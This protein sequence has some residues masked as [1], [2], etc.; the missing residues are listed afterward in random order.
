MLN[1]TYF[2]VPRLESIDILP[3]S[4]DR[5]ICLEKLGYSLKLN[6]VKNKISNIHPDRWTFLRKKLNPLEYPY[7]SNVI[8]RPASRA[9]FKLLE[10]IK[11]MNLDVSGKT[12]HLAEAPGGFIQATRFCKKDNIE[13]YTFSII[14]DEERPVYKR[15]VVNKN[16]VI[17]SNKT[18]GGDICN[19]RNINFL[20]GYF[21]NKNINFITCDGGITENKEFSLKEQMH[22][23]LI[24]SQIYV[25]LNVLNEGG[26]LVVKFFDIYTEL[27]FDF[28]AVLSSVFKETYICKPNTSRPTNSEKYIVCKFFQ[29]ESFNKIKD[30]LGRVLN[31]SIIRYKSIV[32]K[33]NIQ[34]NFVESVKYITKYLS[35]Y[36][37]FNIESI[38]RTEELNISTSNGDECVE[39][40]INKYY[41]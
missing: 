34:K 11:D 22:H 6:N 25:S 40:W 41:Y 28:L 24:F 36:Q 37:I 9:F 35:E 13:S 20:C 16:V 39:N 5:N 10:L 21:K 3:I 1:K 31:S 17:L 32:R 38:I 29:I 8:E 33:H 12:L 14:G 19:I 30:N 18:N 27:T 7:K 4:G 2:R 26:S 15:S 23:N